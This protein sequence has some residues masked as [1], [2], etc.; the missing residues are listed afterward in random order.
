[1][2]DIWG[3]SCWSFPPKDLTGSVSK[4]CSPLSRVA[5]EPVKRRAVLAD[6]SNICREAAAKRPK[7]V[8]V[9]EELKPV[10]LAF[11]NFYDMSN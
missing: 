10:S 3:F 1:M 11:Y 8:K 6:V 9:T 4:H 5:T 7:R 2:G